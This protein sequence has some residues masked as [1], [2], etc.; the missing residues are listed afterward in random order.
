MSGLARFL[1]R[2]LLF[3]LL[4][5]LLVSSASMWLAH[6][7][8]GDYTSEMQRPGVSAETVDRER[9]RLGLDRPLAEQY[10]AWLGGLV[11][12]DLGTS[13]KYDRPVTEF[14]GARARNTA[15]LAFVALLLATGVG[16]PLGVVAGSRSTGWLAPT[17]RGVSVVG[18]S[19][20]PLLT[21]ILLALLAA[22]TG[23]FPIGGM[24]SLRAADLGPLGQLA[25][26]AWHLVLPTLALALPIAAT[27]ERLLARSMR[28]TLDEPFILAALARGI[29][30]RR[31]IWRHALRVAIRPVAS[32]Y[33]IIVGSLLSGSFA[34]ELVTSWPGL[35]QL[36]YEA[37]LARDVQLVA[38]CAAIGSLFLAC[39]N[40][41][42]DAGLV[43]ADPRLRDE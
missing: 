43:A 29:S 40:L 9:A 15:L 32:V 11:R 5:V 21:S 8:P 23:W 30:R 17:I 37:L 4:L 13:F 25:D 1:V 18:L 19:L 3:A 36:M 2:R 39:G 14:I 16:L 12:F 34:V 28:E 26:L 27:L 33:G 31:V 10:L 7:A 24:T 35:G 41:L 38:G 22:R 6:L 42:S 20:P